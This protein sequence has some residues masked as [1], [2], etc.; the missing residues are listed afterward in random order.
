MSSSPLGPLIGKRH[1]SSD[2]T[3]AAT[4]RP[5]RSLYYGWILMGTLGITTIISYGTTEYLFGVLVVPL[6][7]AFHWSRAGISGAYALGFVLSGVL[8]VPI[9]YAVDRWGARWLMTGGSAL[10][11]LVFIALSHVQTLWQLYALWSGGVGLVMALTLYPVS[12]IVVTNWFVR[13]RGT[14]LA[15]LTLLGGLASPIFV[16][17]SGTLVSHLGWQTTLVVLGLAHLFIAL[18]LHGTL[19]RCCP[20]DLGLSAD[21]EPFLPVSPPVPL[22]GLTLTR[23]LQRPAFWTLTASLALVTLAGTV[24]IVHQVASLISR[25][26]DAELAAT[27]AGMLGVASLPGRYVFNVLSER[28]PSQR[29]FG[30]G[31]VVHAIGVVI[32]LKAPDV[33]WLVVYVVLYGAA[34]G[35]ISPLGASVMANHFGRRAYGSIT[36]VQGIAITLCAGVG[37]LVAGWLYDT[38]GSYEVAFWLCVGAFGLAAVGMFLTPQPEN[39]VEEPVAS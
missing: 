8:G 20:E 4:R 26:Y 36:A 12:F 17:L 10:A 38:L 24:I 11:G 14:A 21:G 33:G 16:P 1:P 27:L 31:V 37:I 32:L 29:L 7:S 19:L 28:I 22:S 18:P 2:R 6:T 9:G 25:G 39:V 5:R 15:V 13:R 30:I 3:H 23:A 34:Y 35:A